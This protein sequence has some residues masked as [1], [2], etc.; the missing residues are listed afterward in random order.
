MKENLFET[1]Y[2]VTKKTKIKKFYEK[3]K[4]LIFSSIFILLIAVASYTLYLDKKE[5]RK[6]ILSDNYIKA[7][8]YLHNGNKNEAINM[9]KTII[10]ASDS[11]YSTLSLF[12]LL[13]ENLISDK[14]ELT[15][16][17]NHVIQNHKS[18]NEIKNLII[19]K[20]AL[21]QSNFVNEKDL[22]ESLKPLIN[23]DTI[24]KPHVLLLIGDYFFSKKEY[25]KAK[26]F[27]M[28]ILSLKNLH[29]EFYD[30]ARSHLILISND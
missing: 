23:K 28:E 17:F 12:L 30:H 20:K 1:Q 7:K 26:E 9:L 21:Y 27:Y 15:N 11:T 18:E 16:L 5:K 3:S 22:I 2:D 8:I 25:F 4:I 24:W 13:D 14:V 19:F 6:I 10:S 29:K